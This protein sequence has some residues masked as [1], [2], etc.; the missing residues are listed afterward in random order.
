MDID[1]AKALKIGDVVH[2]PEDRGDPAY[3]G[4]VRALPHSS[5]FHTTDG[6]PY[7]WVYVDDGSGRCSTWPSNRLG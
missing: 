7:I 4:R 1:K 2:C 5:V 6:T 3:T